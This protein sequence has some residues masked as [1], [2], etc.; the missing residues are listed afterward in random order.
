LSP[1]LNRFLSVQFSGFVGSANT[2][3]SANKTNCPTGFGADACPAMGNVANIPR[4]IP[5][6]ASTTIE[7]VLFIQATLVHF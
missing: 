1:F 3:V 6:V 7:G 2:A 5:N 4:K